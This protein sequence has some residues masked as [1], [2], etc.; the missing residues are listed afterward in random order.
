M[1]VQTM[2]ALGRPKLSLPYGGRTKPEAVA[3]ERRSHTLA[4]HELRHLVAMMI[5]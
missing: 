4:D 2:G 3:N 5:D 1:H